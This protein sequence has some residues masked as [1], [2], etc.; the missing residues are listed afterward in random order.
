[1]GPKGGGGGGR[2]TQ[3]MEQQWRVDNK[4]EYDV[5]V[6]TEEQSSY[7]LSIKMLHAC[8]LLHAISQ[9]GLRHNGLLPHVSLHCFRS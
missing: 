1:M 9:Q 3:Q 2:A 4:G 8:V 5:P 6:K 7:A